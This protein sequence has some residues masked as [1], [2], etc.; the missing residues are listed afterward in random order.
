MIQL[1]SHAL[2]GALWVYEA[3]LQPGWSIVRRELGKSP[4]FE[5]ALNSTGTIEPAVKVSRAAGCISAST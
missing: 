3:I 2:Q 4:A 5:K 1:E